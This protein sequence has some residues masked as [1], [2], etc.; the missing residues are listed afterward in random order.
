MKPDSIT[1]GMDYKL[2][3]SKLADGNVKQRR[4][5]NGLI[6]LILN[7]TVVERKKS[8]LRNANVKGRDDNDEEEEEEEEEEEDKEGR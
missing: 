6:R 2:N 8:K 3:Q 5:D 7:W 4:D 1:A